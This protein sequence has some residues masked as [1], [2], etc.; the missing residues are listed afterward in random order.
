MATVVS[1]LDKE[2]IKELSVTR[3]A[4][5]VKGIYGLLKN[6]DE[7]REMLRN[8][9]NTKNLT[10]LQIEQTLLMIVRKRKNK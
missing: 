6:D 3:N 1:S 9:R 7:K 2:L 8:C 10:R 4:N 5:F